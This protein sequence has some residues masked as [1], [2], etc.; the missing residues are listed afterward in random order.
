MPIVQISQIKHRRGF[1]ENLPQ[2]GTAE[3]GFTIDTRRLF[4]GSGTR[5]EGAPVEENIEIITESSPAWVNVLASFEDSEFNE[6]LTAG[7]TRLT[8][9]ESLLNNR[10]QESQSLYTY[11]PSILI[12]YQIRKSDDS[13]TGIFKVSKNTSTNQICYEDEYV[14]TSDMG[15]TMTATYNGS[16]DPLT[17]A[18][19]DINVIMPSGSGHIS[20]EV[21]VY[22]KYSS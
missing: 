21:D 16:G 12:K 8:D 5:E 6:T 20:Y 10:V 3:L 15:I 13:R 1:E 4:I 9:A 2:L 11:T 7:T 17:S 18:L 19:I 22:S 14:E